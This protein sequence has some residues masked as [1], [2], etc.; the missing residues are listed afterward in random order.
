MLT[1]VIALNALRVIPASDPRALGILL[2]G[3]VFQGKIA[4]LHFL[5]YL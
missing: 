3:Y 2:T 1:G 5:F 4:Y